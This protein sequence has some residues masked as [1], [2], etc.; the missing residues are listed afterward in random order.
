MLLFFQRISTYNTDSNSDS[1]CSHLVSVSIY[2][3]LRS[4][5]NTGLC[6][7]GQCWLL[8]VSTR[9][10][11]SKP[12]YSVQILICFIAYI[13]QFSIH[14]WGW[15]G[16]LQNY[17]FEPESRLIS[18]VLELGQVRLFWKI[19]QV[20]NLTAVRQLSVQN[21]SLKVFFM[22][23]GMK[24]SP[25][26][27]HGFFKYQ[28]GC[29]TNVSRA[30]QNSPA[31]IH[32]TRN[33]IYGENFKLKLCTCACFGHTYKVSAWNSHKNDDSC[34]TQISREYWRVRETLVVVSHMTH[35]PGSSLTE[36]G[37]VI[38]IAIGD[39]YRFAFF[40]LVTKLWLKFQELIY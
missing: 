32:N 26:W 25:D 12:R 22:Q 20:N 40:G 30:L 14:L 29:F 39:D 31:K 38:V 17:H 37:A 34:N 27:Q 2:K 7:P 16:T 18:G 15:L 33:H 24:I 13:F 10:L 8:S 3:R 9:P 4:V 1:F 28:G 23:L 36:L 11:G 19:N 5:L 6:C 35:E 21:L